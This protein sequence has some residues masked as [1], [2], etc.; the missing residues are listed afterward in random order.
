MEIPPSKGP[1]ASLDSA[2]SW[3]P[4]I[5]RRIPW[6]G[7]SALFGAFCATMAA[8]GILVASDGMQ[9][10]NWKYPPTVYL[11]VAYTISNILVA[12][13]FSEAVTVSQERDCTKTRTY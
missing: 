8:I 11:S 10:Q 3:R 13:A 7:I 1:Y 5:F 2:H 6:S 12:A 4:G 9:I